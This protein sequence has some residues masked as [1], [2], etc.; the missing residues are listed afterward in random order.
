MAT[1]GISYG[2]GFVLG[3]RGTN[4]VLDNYGRWVEESR[5][6]RRAAIQRISEMGVKLNRENKLKREKKPNKAAKKK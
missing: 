2:G 3:W 4:Y 5:L 6:K 1:V